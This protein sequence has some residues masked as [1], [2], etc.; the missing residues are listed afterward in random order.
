MSVIKDVN[1]PDWDKEISQEIVLVDFWAPWCE[2]C[3]FQEKILNTII[4]KVDIKIL[5]LN[6]DDNRWLSQ[7]IGVRNIPCIIIYKDSKEVIRLDGIQSG[8]N[9]ISSINKLN[10]IK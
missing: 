8:D 3:K 10:N 9:L 6:I 1:T 5:K 7:N 4:N 2:S